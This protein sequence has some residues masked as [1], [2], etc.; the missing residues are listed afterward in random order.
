MCQHVGTVLVLLPHPLISSLQP[1]FQSVSLATHTQP[2]TSVFLI[3]LFRTHSCSTSLTS[4]TSHSTLN[5][6]YARG[7][8]N[9]GGSEQ[10]RG[11][12]RGG[13]RGKW[14]DKFQKTQY[15]RRSKAV[16]TVLSEGENERRCVSGSSALFTSTHDP[17]N[18]W[19]IKDK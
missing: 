13:R 10:G 19:C 6:M 4:R 11:W 7:F 14:R 8:A 17:T 18:P 15:Y 16:R 1:L 12:V 3:Y 5:Y 2:P 9:N